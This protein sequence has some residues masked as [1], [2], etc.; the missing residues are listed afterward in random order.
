VKITQFP[1]FNNLQ[2]LMPEELDEEEAL[3]WLNELDHPQNLDNFGNFE[4]GQSSENNISLDPEHA[5]GQV[6]VDVQ[7]GQSQ[8]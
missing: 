1:V 3:G 7:L 2:P 8:L 6:P 5:Q 4:P